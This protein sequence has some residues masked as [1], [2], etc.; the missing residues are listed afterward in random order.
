[1]P[2]FVAERERIGQ[3]LE[4]LLAPHSILIL[5]LERL[6]QRLRVASELPVKFRSLFIG[7]FVP[8]DQDRKLQIAILGFDNFIHLLLSILV[9]VLQAE[10]P[11]TVVLPFSSEFILC[12]FPNRFLGRSS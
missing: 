3:H 5:V 11:V 8:V 10:H 12:N 7:R 2:P 1:M 9:L 6:P 4:H